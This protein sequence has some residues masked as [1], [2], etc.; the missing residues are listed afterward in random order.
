MLNLLYVLASLILLAWSETQ[1]SQP[2]TCMQATC[3]AQKKYFQKDTSLMQ[4]AHHIPN[5]L[6]RKPADR[7]D[8]SSDNAKP[9]E[10]RMV[11]MKEHVA[12]INS[13]RLS[14]GEFLQTEFQ[15]LLDGEHYNPECGKPTSSDILGPYH[16]P[17]EFIPNSNFPNRDVVC[18]LDGDAE[19]WGYHEGV[20]YK[21]KG[22]VKSATDC[23]PLAG[24]QVDICQSDPI[25]R[26]WVKDHAIPEGDIKL[27]SGIKREENAGWITDPDKYFNCRATQVTN[28]HG[29][30]SFQTYLPGRYS[31]GGFARPRHM[32]VR[33]TAPGHKALL[34]QTFYHGDSALG[35]ADLPNSDLILT[36][37]R[38]SASHAN[39]EFNLHDWELTSGK[40]KE[41]FELWVD[42]SS[43]HDPKLLKKVQE[44]PAC[45]LH[46][47][48]AF[49]MCHRRQ[50]NRFSNAEAY[51][52]C[53]AQVDRCVAD[54]TCAPFCTDTPEMEIL[55][56]S[57]SMLEQ[58]GEP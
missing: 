22:T 49:S 5:R 23:K 26:Y 48:T 33:I 6:N 57:D 53:R 37:R 12:R 56:L 29:E 24:A 30:F 40:Q 47:S 19:R 45:S 34:T 52:F 17:P 46:C 7:T 3:N 10:S 55:Q 32:H 9:F 1:S 21:F 35:A 8:I 44:G 18:F 2:S 20:P 39:T 15:V 11:Q 4:L 41:D 50:T 31:F 27:M 36:M 16:L 25:G 51:R 54:P 58:H 13:L 38:F 28:E 42:S 14:P 43:I